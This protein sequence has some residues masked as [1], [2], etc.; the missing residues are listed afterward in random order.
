MVAEEFRSEIINNFHN[1]KD[2]SS[3]KI[4]VAEK[5]AIL[6]FIDNMSDRNIMVES[7]IKPLIAMQSITPP[8]KNILLDT[9]NLV[10]SLL[11]TNI[12]DALL[13]IASGNV[14][15][16]IDG[17]D[18]IF[19]FDIRKYNKRAIVE[20]PT[21]SVL[22]GP[23][24]GFNEDLKDNMTLM[25]RK[26]RSPDF[27]F[28]NT[29]V[30]EYS[31]TS[32]AVCYIDGVTN[33]EVVS[34]I[35]SKIN[36]IRIDGIVD[37]SYISKYLEERPYSFLRQ[38]GITEKPDI[39]AAKLL[40]GRVGVI[41]DGS[42]IAITFPHIF[43]E[44][45][46]DSSDYFKKEAQSSFLRILRFLGIIM[47]TFLPAIYVAL[48]EFHYHLIPFT[49]LVTIMNATANIPLTPPMEM[50]VVLLA[51]EVLNEASIRMPRYVGMALSIVGA[52]ALGTTAVDAGLLSSP[53]VLV[54]AL[55]S[56][57]LYCVPQEV[58]VFSLLRILFVCIA[59]VLGLYGLILSLL[60][61]TVY[62][63]DM[64]SYGS[65][66]LTPFAPHNERDMQDSFFKESLIDIE[67]RPNSVSSKDKKRNS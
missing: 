29:T 65:P 60:L 53:A 27:V 36:D 40:E 58:S 48:L 47:A 44:S 67:Y 14:V 61:L 22:K 32:V 56:I 28:H 17:S 31:K 24:E 23:R 3:I 10:S 34:K 20:P 39:L 26:L 46:Q 4:K 64:E 25:R 43:W 7:I 38:N 19:I 35:I 6:M 15:L 51:F 37:S 62:V 9:L 42:P 49:L 11:I 33:K 8:Y 52:I 12:H 1:S 50:V 57:G 18:E 54:S 45:F 2:L 13:Y 5:D 21:A 63:L 30:G 55:S 66:Y 16:N 59:G 41:V